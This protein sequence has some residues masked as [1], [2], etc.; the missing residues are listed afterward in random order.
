MLPITRSPCLAAAKQENDHS[1]VPAAHGSKQEKQLVE[2]VHSTELKRKT[3]DH[4]LG[5]VGL[6]TNA[7]KRVAKSI[8]NMVF[9]LDRASPPTEGRDGDE[10]DREQNK[11]IS[12]NSPRI[13]DLTGDSD[14][15]TAREQTPRGDTLAASSA[16]DGEESALAQEK[17]QNDACVIDLT[18]PSW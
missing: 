17:V 15:E 14:D 8:G 4:H 10:R 5:V 12:A 11:S 3:S 1:A 2:T 7:S 13:F 16:S 18:G 9:G 6:V